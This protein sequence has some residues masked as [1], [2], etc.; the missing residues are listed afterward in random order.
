MKLAKVSWQTLKNEYLNAEYNRYSA[1]KCLKYWIT[2]YLYLLCP[3]KCI[4]AG[5]YI[6]WPSFTTKYS[7]M[8]SYQDLSLLKLARTECI[9]GFCVQG[10]YNYILE[11]NLQYDT[12]CLLYKSRLNISYPNCMLSSAKFSGK[13][14]LHRILFTLFYITAK[15]ISSKATYY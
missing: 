1:K 15:K 7:S 10:V 11:Q 12:P 5:S 13:Y 8:F 2:K 9:P 3:R 14:V 6:L 4:S